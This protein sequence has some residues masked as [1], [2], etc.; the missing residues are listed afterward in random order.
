MRRIG[1]LGVALILL[2][3][4]ASAA[5]ITTHVTTDEDEHY[6]WEIPDN[7]RLQ[8]DFYATIEAEE[9]ACPSATKLYVYV[10][11]VELPE[12]WAGASPGGGRFEVTIPASEPGV[13]NKSYETSGNV[14]LD[15]NWNEEHPVPHAEVM[16]TLTSS[17]AWDQGASCIPST[18]IREDSIP[19]HAFR[20]VVVETTT[21][22]ACP[23]DVAEGDCGTVEPEVG[24]DA[25]AASAASLLLLAALV[26]LARRRRST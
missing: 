8:I 5:R 2:A 24:G 11:L 4:P 6:N 26:V 1:L 13:A 15:I 9:F 16:Y 12:P 20:D 7:R 14:F 23:A 10:N 22:D 18:E 17:T 3:P 19:L 21:T 25:P